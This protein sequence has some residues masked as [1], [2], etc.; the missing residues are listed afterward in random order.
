ME[1]IG[2][3][4]KRNKAP[5][6]GTVVRGVGIGIA[7]HA[8]GVPRE[9]RGCVII[10]MGADGAFTVFSGHSDIGTGSN[11]VMI[12]VV[13]ETLDVPMEI[14][15]LQAADS[16]FTPFDNGTYASSNVYRA[17]N[18]AQRAAE[19]MRS[20]LI[21]S[22]AETLGPDAGELFFHDEGFYDSR[23]KLQLTLSQFA[24]KRVTYHEGGD[25]LVTGASFPDDFSPSPYVASCAEVEADR[26]T[27]SYRL[28]KMVTV[29][30]SGRIINPINARVQALGGIVQSIGLAMFEEVKYGGDGLIISKDFQTYKIPCQMDVP[31]LTVEFVQESPE[32]S[33]PFGA[34]SLGEIA[35][36]SP[37]PAI[38]DAL[39]NALG[40]HID[41]LPVTPER[42]FRAMR[43]QGKGAA[44][45][46]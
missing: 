3:E 29:V 34:K 1:L 2:W 20:L 22:A 33:G 18:A 30:D 19:R 26:E 37:A 28:V 44:Y 12:Q 36:G 24:D 39:Y 35:T 5:P 6:G 9:D 7:V 13:A 15:R 27:G 42:L 45:G 32:P 16:G 46:D 25:P 10:S 38:C 14:I 31:D 11:T 23:G 40:V 17:C 8:S 4:E 41:S 21:R 43:E